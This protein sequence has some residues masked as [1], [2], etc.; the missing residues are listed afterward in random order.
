MDR[1]ALTFPLRSLRRVSGVPF[2]EMRSVRRGSGSDVAGT[3][4]YRPGDDIRHIDRFATARLSAATGRDEFVVREHHAE[5]AAR[6]AIVCDTSPSMGL[7]PAELPWLHKDAARDEAARMIAASAA[8]A[9]C[10]VRSLSGD[11][12][13]SLLELG[14]RRSLGPGSF[15]FVLSD[16]LEPLPS[17]LWRRAVARGWEVVPVV[18]QDPLWEQ[19]FPA[20]GGTVLPLR[21][22]GGS[23]I[24]FVRLRRREAEQ[25]RDAHERRHARLLAVFRALGLEPVRLS[26]N[27]PEAILREFLAWADGSRR[28]SRHAA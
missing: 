16:F 18:I 9:R 10:P 15:L 19:S 23:R 13:R 12:E 4:P 3:R 28:L 17:T 21:E 20:V 11:V 22:P 25:R 5:E 6:V 2:G 26:S 24:R 7:F 14:R 8:R 27:E 1:S